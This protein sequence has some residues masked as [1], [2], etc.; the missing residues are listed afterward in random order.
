[1]IA[2]EKVIEQTRIW[3]NDVV[4]GCNFC[5]F[6]AR[7]MKRNSVRYQ[8]IHSTDVANCLQ[9][10]VNECKHLDEHPDTETS[11]VIF[12]VGFPDF[13]AYLDLV[14]LAEEMLETE[15]YEGVYQLASF[16]PEYRFEGAP[17]DDAA[18]Y[19]N[20]SPYPM[21]HLLREE[22]IEKALDHYEG[23]P[24]EIPGRNV[25]FAREKGLIYMKML[26]DT[27]LK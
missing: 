10:L 4:V 20:R 26:R 9:A 24:E 6:A 5:P 25:D 22:S 12:P 17:A 2:S 21:L 8:V 27:C 13:L 16:H 23:D 1:M 14:S 7:E 3:I 11:F 19:T 18:N 15:G